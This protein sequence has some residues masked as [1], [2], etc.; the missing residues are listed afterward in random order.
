MTIL[1]SVD[2]YSSVLGPKG[3]LPA[4]IFSY[5]VVGDSLTWSDDVF[6]IHGFRPGEV[7]PS[8]ELVLAHKHPDDRDQVAEIL[9]RTRITGTP[10]CNYHRL[11]NSRGRTRRVIT[12]GQGIRNADNNVVGIYGMLMDLTSTLASELGPET[13]AAVARS[14]ENRATIEQAKGAVMM[15]FGV[16]ADAAFAI[17]A[18]LSQSTN[19]PVARLCEELLVA[20]QDPE[21]ARNALA[22]LIGQAPVA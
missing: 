21:T 12:V 19:K 8:M 9:Q 18:R 5:D 16:D 11:I 17:L 10:F 20:I 15:Q 6:R 14:A 13:A 22:T 2:S 4:G 1:H 7:V 3:T